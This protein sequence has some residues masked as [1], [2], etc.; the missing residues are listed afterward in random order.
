M[1]CG[2][3]GYRIADQNLPPVPLQWVGRWNDPTQE[4]LWVRAIVPC[5]MLPAPIRGEQVQGN[6]EH[7][8]PLILM[9]GLKQSL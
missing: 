8:I 5:T 7:W 1:G 3:E 6:R 2:E 9:L 4:S